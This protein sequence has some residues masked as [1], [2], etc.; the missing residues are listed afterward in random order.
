MILFLNGWV[1]KNSPTEFG[2]QPVGEGQDKGD[3]T[4]SRI[5]GKSTIIYKNRMLWVIGMVYL[6]WGFSY[7]VFPLF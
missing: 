5:D 2:L 7:L 4:P 1:L 6:T 3:R